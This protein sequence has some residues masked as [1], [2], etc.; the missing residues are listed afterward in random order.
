MALA[1]KGTRTL[2]I[3]DIRYRWVVSRDFGGGENARAETLTLVV[4]LADEPGQRLEAVFAYHDLPNSNVPADRQTISP[5][6]VREI[7]LFALQKKWRPTQRGLRSLRFQEDALPLRL[8][9]SKP[10]WDTINT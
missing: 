5:K 8:H 10:W 6:V 7:I 4:E 9:L 3:N 1:K 2:V